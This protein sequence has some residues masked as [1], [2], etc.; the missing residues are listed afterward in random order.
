MYTD[1]RWRSSRPGKP[2]GL[3]YQENVIVDGGCFILCQVGHPR[4]RRG[5]ESVAGASGETAAQAGVAGSGHRLQA[6]ANSENLLEE[7]GITAY[8][9]IHPNQETNMV[10][11]GDFIYHGDHL[12][13]PQGKLLRRSAFM[14]R[15]RA[16]QYV[17]HQEDCHSCPVKTRCLPPNQKRR[18]VAL[19]MYHPLLLRVRERNQTAE[20][21]R[22]RKRR[23]TIAE[24]IFASL[25]RL[26]WTRSRLRGLR[27]VDCD[28]YMAGLAH[29]VL[30]AVRWLRDDAGP[31]SPLETQGDGPCCTGR[32][33]G[34]PD[35][36]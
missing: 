21:R 36:S 33:E 14:R 27:K 6:S 30:K 15:D 26:G 16:Y 35:A 10:S 13:C 18:Y 2:T 4:V 11:K 20:Y 24:G 34:I 3:H 9:P 31:A 8:I 29:N 32:S 19:S 7:K 22:E 17:A 25:D 28:G 12:T 5:R 1:A 23:R